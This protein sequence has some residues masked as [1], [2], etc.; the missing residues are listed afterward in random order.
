M[1]RNRKTRSYKY[2]EWKQGKLQVVKQR[3]TEMS[4]NSQGAVIKQCVRGTGNTGG[5]CFDTAQ[6]PVCCTAQSTLHFTDMKLDVTEI[7][8]LTLI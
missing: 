2:Q 4:G 5:I 1:V 6:Y 7:I 3:G 8:M